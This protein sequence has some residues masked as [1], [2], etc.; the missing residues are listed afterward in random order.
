MSDP[1]HDGARDAWLSQALRHAPDSNAAPPTALSE[2]ILAEARAAAARPMP[3]LPQRAHV[4]ARTLGAVLSSWWTALARPPVAAAF[5]SLMVATLV[6]VMW[7]DRPMDETLPRPASPAADQIAASPRAATA[8]AATGQASTPAAATTSAPAPTTAAAPA[9]APAEPQANARPSAPVVAQGRLQGAATNDRVAPA[10]AARK[11]EAPAAF[12]PKEKERD[13]PRARLDEAKKDGAP[14][15]F[16][17][18]SATAPPP[19]RQAENAKAAGALAT[20]PPATPPAPVAAAPTPPTA[21]VTA[22]PNAPALATAPSPA[23]PP[24]SGRGVGQ[25]R[26]EASADRADKA[27]AKSGAPSREAPPPA[28]A[29]PRQ[30]DAAD[31]RESTAALE[32]DRTASAAAPE[33]FVR[34]AAPDSR[35]QGDAAAASSPLMPLLD[36]IEREPQRWTR[37]T[38]AGDTAS[39][40][41]AWRAWLAELDAAASGRWQPI[42]APPPTAD[43]ERRDGPTL[44]LF[45][46][47]RAAATVRVEG[48]TVR[49]DASLGAAPERWQASL[50]PAAAVRLATA[51]ARL[52][53]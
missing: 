24:D 3:S 27:L 42:A 32:R 19:A 14:S 6:G 15:S 18:P 47:G 50:A 22:T 35:R 48:Q 8:P 26:S 40:D 7:W 16:A 46:D 29:T 5:A 34:R 37:R 51:R 13:V 4:D 39:L 38:L 12:P 33:A 11:S 41:A 52:S 17:A 1:D 53:P 9:A 30:R 25:A 31:E 43:D 21:T 49:L 10:A 23:T 28:G 20:A 2:A 44:R 45:V 36:A